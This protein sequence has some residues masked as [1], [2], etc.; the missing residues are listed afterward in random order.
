MIE[1]GY[2]DGPF[3]QVHW[4]M[5]NATEKNSPDLF[6][7]HPAPFSGLAFT[8]IMPPLATGRRVIAP[9]F[10]GYGGSGRCDV[11]PSID[12]YAAAMSAVIDDLSGAASVDL[13]GFHT[14]CLVAGALCLASPERFRR[15]VLIDCPT[16]DR[17]QREALRDKI[18]P[19]ALTP[20]LAC[21][22]APWAS[23]VTK[24]LQS[25][26]MDRAFEMFVEQLR[27]GARMNDA[28]VA[29]FSYEWEKSLPNV[30]TNTLV[31]ATQSPL[32]DPSRNA[33]A[34][35]PNARLIERLDIT[36]AVLD[37]AAEKT[38]AEVLTF[39]DDD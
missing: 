6:C 29:A 20:D 33:A 18:K 35:I 28:F 34:I 32:L 36:R 9:D 15:A 26:P 4:R 12:A 8:G 7:F 1:K 39:L 23:G 21:L 31:I 27:Q 3:G 13:L 5:A 22:E 2:T 10:P 11:E 25:Q 19:L 38:A 14:G 16:F 30:K 17:R 37:E 24:R